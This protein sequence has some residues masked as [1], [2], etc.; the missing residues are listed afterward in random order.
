MVQSVG[1]E[2]PNRGIDRAG[3]EKHPGVRPVRPPA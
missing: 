2:G 3:M 1:V